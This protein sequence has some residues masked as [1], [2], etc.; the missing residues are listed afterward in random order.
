MS[1]QLRRT[2]LCNRIEKHKMKTSSPATYFEKEGAS[3]IRSL[4]AGA[5]HKKREG[6]SSKD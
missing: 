4:V 5:V 3:S 6:E 1:N 2:A